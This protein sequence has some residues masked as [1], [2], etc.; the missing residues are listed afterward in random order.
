MELVTASYLGNKHNICQKYVVQLLKK[1]K[2]KPVIK[3][4]RFNG[5]NQYDSAAAEKV[6]L[7]HFHSIKIQANRVRVEVMLNAHKPYSQIAEHVGIPAGEFVEAF[8]YWQ[9]DKSEN[10]AKTPTKKATDHLK[11]HWSFVN[12][13]FNR[14]LAGGI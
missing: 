6:L 1:Q 2:I 4:S 10:Q 11:K 14:T 8:K 12:T 9:N 5:P 13:V 7:V 3:T